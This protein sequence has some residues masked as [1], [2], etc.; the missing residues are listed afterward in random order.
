MREFN[1]PVHEVLSTELRVWKIV[2]RCLPLF[3]ILTTAPQP[4]QHHLHFIHV[5]TNIQRIKSKITQLLSNLAGKKRNYD[6]TPK[7]KCLSLYPR[8][9]TG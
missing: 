8:P 2:S 4:K 6:Q 7:P 5:E 1:E 9:E 3:L